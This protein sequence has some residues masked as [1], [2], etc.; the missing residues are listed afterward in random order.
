ML[1]GVPHH[2]TQRGN[3]RQ[4]VFHREF[5]R[6]VYLDRLFTYAQ[7]YGIRIWGYC[8]MPNHVHGVL[9]PDRPD[10][11][12]HVMQRTAADYARYANVASGGCGHLWQARFYS[13]AMDEAYTWRALT[14]IERNPVRAGMVASAE[15][16]HWSSARLHCG[17]AFRSRH[18]DMTEWDSR[19]TSAM[20]R[21]ALQSSL[22]DAMLRERL[23]KATR[24]GLPLGDD[25]FIDHASKALQRD[26]HPQ[27]PGRPKL[28]R[29]EAVVPR[30]MK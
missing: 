12:A 1:V 28:R 16:Y 25:S 7:R 10:S 21:D 22:A 20:W 11:L 13:C 19:F 15:E 17:L 18:I 26:L 8:L 24:S 3:N 27:P 4:E 5:D 9:V 2:V 23:A 14:Y 6:E 29:V 30:I